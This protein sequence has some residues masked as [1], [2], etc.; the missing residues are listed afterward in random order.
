MKR[1]YTHQKAENNRIQTQVNSIKLEK[2]ALHQTLIG[3]QRRTA[4]LELQI[5]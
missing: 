4:D 5:G 3:L 2:T 1:H